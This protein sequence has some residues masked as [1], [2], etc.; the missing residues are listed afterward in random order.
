MAQL[1]I[2]ADI[3][4]VLEKSE[5]NLKQL[6]RGAKK[7]PCYEKTDSLSAFYFFTLKSACVSNF[8]PSKPEEF[9]CLFDDLSLVYWKNREFPRNTAV[10]TDYKNDLKYAVDNWSVVCPISESV[11]HELEVEEFARKNSIGYAFQLFDVNLLTYFLIDDGS[12]QVIDFM[13][14]G[15]RVNSLEEFKKCCFK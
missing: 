14:G 5:S 9:D 8:D 2:E 11:W 6:F 1:S 3:S 4:R 12:I 7:L 13:D 15:M 10:L